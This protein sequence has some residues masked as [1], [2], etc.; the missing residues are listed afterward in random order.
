M[1][2][3][4]TVRLLRHGFVPAEDEFNKLSVF[5]HL[6]AQSLRVV[7][8][9]LDVA[10]KGLRLGIAVEGVVLIPRP[11]V[12]Q[13]VAR[14]VVFVLCCHTPFGMCGKSVALIIFTFAMASKP[15]MA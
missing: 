11:A 13:Q 4:V 9:D 12:F 10:V 3:D 5:L 1:A 15:Y 14:I 6:V 2:D 8:V 7:A